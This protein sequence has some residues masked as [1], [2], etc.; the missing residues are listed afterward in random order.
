M[1]YA[2]DNHHI[3]WWNIARHEKLHSTMLKTL[4]TWSDQ[5]PVLSTK[6]QSMMKYPK[7]HVVVTANIPPPDDLLPRRCISVKTTLPEE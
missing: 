6:Y 2:Y 3:V 4:E 1:I 5:T 7:C